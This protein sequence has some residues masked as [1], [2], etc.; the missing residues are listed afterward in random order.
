MATGKIVENYIGETR[1]ETDFADHIA[2]TISADPK[3]K[4]IFICDRLNTHASESLVRMVA[5][6]IGYRQHLGR[7]GKD[8]ILK[9]VKSRK[10]FLKN[11]DHRICFVYTP[12]HCSWHFTSFLN[13]KN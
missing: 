3:G 4:W 5:E 9:N 8:G 12:K 13:L 7:K 6:L 2:K 10:D 11:R 1:T